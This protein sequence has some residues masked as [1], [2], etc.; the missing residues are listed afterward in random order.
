M[1][2]CTVSKIVT[3]VC[4]QIWKILQPEYIPVPS[5]KTW[6]EI[7]EAFQTI[8]GFPN[9]LGSIDGKHIV[10]KCPPNSGSLF[11][12]YKKRFSTV[13]LAIV[14]PHYKFTYIDVGSYGKDSDSTIFEDSSFYQ[15]LKSGRDLN[16]PAPKPLPGFQQTTPHVFIADGGF[17]LATFLM[18]PF[19][20]DAAM[21]DNDKKRFN[22][23][24]SRARVVVE[25]AFGI[26]AQKFRIFLRPFETDLNNT[27][28]IVK[29]AVCLHNLLQ[30]QEGAHT[31]ENKQ[32]S[33]TL[34]A[35]VPMHANRHR[36][37]L[38]AFHVRSQF[39][40]YFKEN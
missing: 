31:Y 13:L 17:K 33:D 27:I 9:C 32:F 19:T 2:E 39:V 23:S 4:E 10:I 8:W 18:R 12:C 15:L 22:K 11:Y 37:D 20:R 30:I 7:A 28:K 38:A 40:N 34:G 35:F 6:L 5:T 3:Q 16:L 36:A 26:L 1:G 25:C 24:L 21:N 29:A 14:D